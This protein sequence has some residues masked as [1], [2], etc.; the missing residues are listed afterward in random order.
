[1]LRRSWCTLSTL[2]KSKRRQRDMTNLTVPRGLFSQI[3][4]AIEDLNDSSE[5]ES[6]YGWRPLLEQVRAV[7]AED[8]TKVPRRH[9][10]SVDETS[11]KC[12]LCK[13][14]LPSEGPDPCLGM[15]P[16]VTFACCGHG[17]NGGYILFENGRLI[18]FRTVYMVGQKEGP[19]DGLGKV[20]YL[21]G[22]K[23]QPPSLSSPRRRK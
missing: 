5:R 9:G 20:R 19:P 18:R 21:F 2:R 13:L 4:K 14:N 10:R 23:D 8:Y 6:Y 12:R 11:K 3:V 17:K 15:L 16:G 1:M 7:A 22:A